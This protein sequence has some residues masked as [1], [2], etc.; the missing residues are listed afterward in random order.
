M[1]LQALLKLIAEAAIG[2]TID[3]YNYICM[4]IIIYKLYIYFFQMCQ[5]ESRKYKLILVLL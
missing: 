4:Y 3:I 1:T 2:S 5:H